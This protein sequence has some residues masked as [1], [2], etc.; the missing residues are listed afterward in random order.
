VQQHKGA[1]LEWSTDHTTVSPELCHDVAIHRV[2]I[3]LSHAFSSFSGL[4]SIPDYF[5]AVR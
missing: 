4:P 3:Y 1:S 5:P 2:E